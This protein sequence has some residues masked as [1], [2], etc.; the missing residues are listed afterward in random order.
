VGWIAF[1]AIMMLVVGLFNVIDG[2]AAI[3]SNKV[4]ISGSGGAVV[5]DVTAW[6][7]VHLVI[8]LL[9]AVVG[10]FLLQGASWATYAAIVLVIVNMLTQMMFLPAYPLWSIMIIALDS[11]VLWALIV[12]GDER[13]RDL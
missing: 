12:H 4:F 1:A 2:I 7:W 5:L 9:V 13:V 10:Y 3:A 6:G 11:F 8:G